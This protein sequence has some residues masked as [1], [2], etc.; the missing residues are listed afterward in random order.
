MYNIINGKQIGRIRSIFILHWFLLLCLQVQLSSIVLWSSNVCVHV[1]VT[2]MKLIMAQ[3]SNLIISC[4][5]TNLF[6]TTVTGTA[7]S[8]YF[9][10]SINCSRPQAH[11]PISYLWSTSPAWIQ[12][13]AELINLAGIL[14]RGDHLLE[15]DHYSS[16][17]LTSQQGQTCPALAQHP[18]L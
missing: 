14:W 8:L 9:H 2:S 18:H 12:Q 3:T 17:M 7:V 16:D 15:A 4:T 5:S 10:F 1:H 11:N 6:G 13:P